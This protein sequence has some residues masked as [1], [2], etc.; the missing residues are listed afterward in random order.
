MLE[1]FL[2]A[3]LLAT[4]AASAA[5]AQ[6]RPMDDPLIGKL[7]GTWKVTGTVRGKPVDQQLQAAWVLEH[8]FMLLH[9]NGGGYEAQ[10]FIGADEKRKRYVVHWIDVT[11]GAYSEPIGYGQAEGA[12]RFV[13][14]FDYPESLF[15]DTFSFDG[16]SWRMLIE[17]RDKSG[18]WKTFAEE[19]FTR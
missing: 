4:S 18:N 15:K 19:R 9:F 12:D 11:G 16:T 13:V 1:R 7:A 3:A 14:T 17:S 2:V 8:Q 10:V 6:R 5:D